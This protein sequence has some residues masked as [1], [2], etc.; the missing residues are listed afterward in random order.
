M[1]GSRMTRARR[2]IAALLALAAYVAAVIIVILDLGSVVSS[3]GITLLTLAAASV[4]GWYALTRRGVVRLVNAIL[5]VLLLVAPIVAMLAH[6]VAVD[7]VAVMGLFVAATLLTRAAVGVD[8][9]ALRAEAP[10]GERVPAPAHPVLLM[11]PWSGGGKVE[12]FTSRT[13]R[14]GE[15]SNRSCCSEVTTS[16]SSRVMRS[17]AVPTRS[18]WRAATA[19]SRPSS[20][21]TS[22]GST[23]AS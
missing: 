2:R 4:T 15:G 14:G 8:K 19:R 17:R 18:G 21:A 1:A 10:P 13:K 6:A 20:T 16:R 12:S 3:L 22:A 5:T 23:S 11:N 7:L 9:E